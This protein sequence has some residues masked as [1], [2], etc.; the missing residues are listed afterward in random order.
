MPVRATPSLSNYPKEIKLCNGAVMPV[1]GLGLSHNGGYN[2]TTVVRS[3]SDGVRLL[4]TAARY[5]NETHVGRALRESKVARTDIFVT[6]KLWPGD[7]DDVPQACRQSLANLGIDHIDLYL[8]HWPAPWGPSQASP[9]AFRSRVWADMI[10]LQAAGLCREIGVSNFQ[11]RHLSQ[12]LEDFPDHPPAVNQIELNPL[13][14]DRALVGFCQSRGIVVEGYC[15]LAKGALVDHPVP[16]RIGRSYGKTAAQVCLRW[17]LQ[18]NTVVIPKSTNFLRVQA[19]REVF[20]FQ[21]SAQDVAELD[22]LHCNMRC[23]WDPSSLE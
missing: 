4:D 3:L 7:A 20:D 9:R 15:P 14:Y 11:I 16:T 12:L 10:A 18:K 22:A 8:V 5:N 2:H 1:L 13:Q 21:L 17:C 23:T 19:N 6:T